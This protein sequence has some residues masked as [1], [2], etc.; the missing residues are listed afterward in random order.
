MRERPRQPET[1]CRPCQVPRLRLYLERV[2]VTTVPLTRYAARQCCQPHQE[3]V[4]LPSVS[5]LAV[6]QPPA[7]KPLHA[8][9]DISFDYTRS[10]GPTLSAFMTALARGRI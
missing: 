5:E 9:L 7:E 8:P 6:S 2:L 3:R 10:L 1:I 4:S